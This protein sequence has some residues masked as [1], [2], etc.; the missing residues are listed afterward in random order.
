MASPILFTNDTWDF[1]FDL[2][3]TNG[4]LV[5]LNGYKLRFTIK[6]KPDTDGE[7]DDAENTVDSQD[8]DINTSITY[9]DVQV[10]K[11]NTGVAPWTY[12]AGFR[13]ITPAWKSKNVE[14]QITVK[15]SIT[16]RNT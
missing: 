13:Y 4:N 7:D 16:N 9:K 14:T 11:E 5:N 15:Q 3:D 1:R 10:A 8:F 2:T 6:K 12:Y